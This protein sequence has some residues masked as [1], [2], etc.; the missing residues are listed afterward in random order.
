MKMNFKLISPF[1]TSAICKVPNAIYETNR[2]WTTDHSVRLNLPTTQQAILSLPMDI[3]EELIDLNV[4]TKN[5]CNIIDITGIYSNGYLEPTICVTVPVSMENIGDES[6]LSLIKNELSKDILKLSV[7]FQLDLIITKDPTYC[8]F[9][10]QDPSYSFYVHMVGLESHVKCCETHLVTVLKLFTNSKLNKPIFVEY[11]DIPSYS[12]LPV[13]IGVDMV[14]VKHMSTTYKADIHLPSLL[15]F[16]EDLKAQPQIFFSGGNRSLIS[17]AK[18][19]MSE[20]IKKA[21]DNMFYRKFSSVSPAKLLFIRKF[22]QQEIIKLMIKYHSFIKV[23][24]YSIEFQASSLELLEI[25]TKVFTAKI[26]H[27]IVEIQ[28]IMDDSFHFTNENIK[29]ILDVSDKKQII[30]MQSLENTNQIVIVGKHTNHMYDNEPFDKKSNISH[31]LSSLFSN[32]AILKATK[33]LKAFFEIHP[34][35][36]EFISG[37]KNGKLTRIMEVS[38]CL[39]S[40]EMYEN[41]ENMF[42][43][44]I[45]NT[46]PEFLS[47]FLQFIDELPAEE[48]FFIPEVYH[49]PVIGSGGSVIQTTMR[50]HNV[51]IQFSNSF[52]L[53]QNEFS[54]IRYDNVIIRCPTKN[55]M[56][57]KMAKKELNTLAHNYG[58]LQCKTLVKFTPGQYRYIL[59]NGSNVI[60]QIE[61]TMNGYIMFPF[62]EPKEGY[63][64]EIRGN[65]ENSLA[66]AEELIKSSFGLETEIY[67]NET[68]KDF[69]SFYNTVL[70]PFKRVMS[71]EVT[72]HED[73]IRLTYG[74]DNKQFSKAL[75]L[76]EEY[77]RSINLRI[78]KQETFHGVIIDPETTPN[79]EGIIKNR[80]LNQLDQYQNHSR[81]QNKNSGTFIKPSKVYSQY[82]YSRYGYSYEC[83]NGY[84]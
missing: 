69:D 25:I 73:M 37:K 32:E 76:L 60:S 74:Q 3:D 66:A 64:L 36:E 54:H 34:D 4:L 62:E 10:T 5:D 52:L 45:A 81:L 55:E 14:N 17:D 31:Y 46:Y 57:I 47:A 9:N 67:L 22:C 58:S 43:S 63:L 21:K 40:L 42:L 65:N 30:A 72:F 59:S 83:E 75:L 39:I 19:V 23:T 29:N 26:L 68:I 7:E 78:V 44:L 20:Y 56:G 77:L 18:F 2:S 50:K 71:I 48:S 11:L 38:E 1:S 70:V 27:N 41:D 12:L 49:R 8:R 61:K 80:N 28:L 16:N 13:C 35:Y 51:F 24:K 6:I 53:P 79:D 82:P 15:S 33:Q 84:R